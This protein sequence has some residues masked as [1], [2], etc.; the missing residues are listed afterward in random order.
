[1]DYSDTHSQWFVVIF[2]SVR[3]CHCIILSQ[4]ANVILSFNVLLLVLGAN[5]TENYGYYSP[6]CKVVHF[7]TSM[8]YLNNN[9]PADDTRPLVFYPCECALL[10]LCHD[11]CF[12]LNICIIFGLPLAGI[13]IQTV[14]NEV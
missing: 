10:V 14:A 9:W 11:R 7:R 2:H 1:M 13:N 4:L 6:Q 3:L 5:K 12:C 8:I